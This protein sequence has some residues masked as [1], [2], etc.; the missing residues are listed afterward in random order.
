[1]I[2]RAVFLSVLWDLLYSTCIFTSLSISIIH[3]F[4]LVNMST[5]NHV[6]ISNLS[7]LM[8]DITSS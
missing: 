8:L 3:H 6:V 5:C 2:V 1:M 4:N 7:H